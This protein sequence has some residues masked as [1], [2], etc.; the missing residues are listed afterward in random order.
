[1]TVY[2][3]MTCDSDSRPLMTWLTGQGSAGIA[4][5]LGVVLALSS[6]LAVDLLYV[7]GWNEEGL[8]LE[9]KSDLGV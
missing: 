6:S 9:D 8:A 3:A 1:V 2:F 7:K 5:D 4:A